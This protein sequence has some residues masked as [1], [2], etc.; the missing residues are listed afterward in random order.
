MRKLF[1]VVL[2][3]TFSGLA[4][5]SPRAL[6][7]L[8]AAERSF[9]ATCDRIG[10][11]DS[12]LQFFSD[13]VVTVGTDLRKG[14]AY[15]HNLPTD[16]S[17]GQKLHWSPSYGDIS[18]AADL[19]Y[20]TGPFVYTGKTG[21]VEYGTYFSIWRREPGGEWKVILDIGSST[22]VPGSKGSAEFHPAPPVR[23]R[24]GFRTARGFSRDALAE[25]ERRF[26]E[27]AQQNTLNKALLKYGDVTL[28]LHRSGVLP[29]GDT[30]RVGEYLAL[31]SKSC[32]TE[33]VASG[34]SISGD[35]GFAYGRYEMSDAREHGF[36]VHVWRRNE[37]GAWRIVLD[38]LHPVPPA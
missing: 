26:A 28:R 24:R 16:W 27:A 31:P 32:K 14:K 10:I 23:N 30:R 6:A 25:M 3:F 38:T 21:E 20:T 7:G 9:A 13:D 33:F 19:G 4:G 11:R 29:I 12:F 5:Q 36:Y 22:P 18:L 17:N 37:K 2:I 35:L 34:I 8:V 1:T 15:L